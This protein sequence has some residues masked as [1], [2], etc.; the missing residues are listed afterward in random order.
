MSFKDVLYGIVLGVVFYF[1]AHGLLPWWVVI[2]GGLVIGVQI[3]ADHKVRQA[4]N[5]KEQ[6][7]GRR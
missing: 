6:R 1:A 7:M 2:F 3:I 4:N 5:D